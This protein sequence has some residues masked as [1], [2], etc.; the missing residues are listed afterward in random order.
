MRGI[1]KM[2][3]QV[4]L[5]IIIVSFNV[6]DYLLACVA[7]IKKNTAGI[8]Y[9]IIIVDNN[10]SDNS[11]DAVIEAYPD[12][13]L[14]R[15]SGNPGF[16]RAN[17]QA[18][19]KSAGEFL[20]LLNPDT[21]VKPGAI[22][23]VL[24]F[25][26]YEKTAAIAG[27]RNVGPDGSLQKSITPFPSV[28]R[29]LAQAFFIDRLFFQE[30]KHATYYRPAPFK[31]D[32][33]GGAFMMVRRVALNGEQLLNSDY[34]MYSE[35]K[36][37]ALRLKRTGWETWFLPT[38]EIIHHGGKSTDQIPTQMFLELHKS[39]IRYFKV[40]GN[41]FALSLSWWMVLV[42]GMIASMPFCLTI[43]GK[44]RFKLFFSAAIAFPKLWCEVVAENK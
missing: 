10:S 41:A 38:A 43:R 27:C 33:V 20:L 1:N 16:A 30:R 5:S 4:E 23:R 9:E 7:S 21:E 34:F 26:K 13:K 25:I 37:L 44:N 3:P 35:E 15:N 31:V 17:N 28:L 39:Q 36:D 42:S 6:R 18:F 2:N 32:S 8:A 14:I 29:N 19:E 12:V 11:A 22:E 24:E 40:A